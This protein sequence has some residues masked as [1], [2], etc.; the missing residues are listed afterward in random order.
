MKKETVE[1]AIKVL[2]N[3]IKES[4]EMFHKKEVSHSYI[5]GMLQGAMSAVAEF[6]EKQ[7]ERVEG[8]EDTE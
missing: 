7:V 2:K 4:D 3:S 1:M 6:L 5:V 8:L